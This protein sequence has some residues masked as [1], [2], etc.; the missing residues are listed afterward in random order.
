[1]PL[2]WAAENG[3]EAVVKTLLA[4]EDVNPNTPDT[5]YGQTPLCWAAENGHEA[6]VK[7][8]LARED[9]NPNTPDT[10][11]GQTPL[12]WAARNG[13]EAVVK[14]LLA[15]EDVNPNMPDTIYGRTPLGWAARKGHEAVIKTLLAQEGV[16]TNT[17]DNLDK[18]PLSMAHSRGRNQIVKILQK[19]ISHIS[20]PTQY[21]GQAVTPQSAGHGWEYTAGMLRGGSDL[22]P[23]ITDPEQPNVNLSTNPKKRKRIS[24]YDE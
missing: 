12:C 21:G 10:R 2:C 11:Y 17:P 5:E 4:R 20:N 22:G 1:T 3:H 6:V 19:K 23:D 18:T 16:H 13:H 9:V 14:A 15:R 8:L 24:S 7:T